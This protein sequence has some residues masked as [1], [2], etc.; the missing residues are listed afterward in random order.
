[1]SHPVAALRAWLDGSW[2]DACSRCGLCCYEREVDE[3]GNVAVNLGAPCEFLDERSRTCRV[4]D[5][6]FERCDRCHRLTPRVVLFSDHLPPSC[7]YL[8][9]FR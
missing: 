6:R 7:G 1:M 4:Y 9:K 5:E 3:D 2:D 8:R